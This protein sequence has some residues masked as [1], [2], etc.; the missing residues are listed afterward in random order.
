MGSL[1]TGRAIQLQ[2]LL[3]CHDFVLD[4]GVALLAFHVVLG[5]V[6]FVKEGGVVEGFHTIRKVVAGPTPIHLSGT[7]SNGYVG[8]AL[9]A[10]NQIPNNLLM[11]DGH[12]LVFQVRGGRVASQ[13]P[14]QRLSLG[15]ILE[16]TEGAGGRGYG[17]VF[18]LDDLGMT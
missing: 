6:D 18:S 4:S 14:A 13:A 15:P 9:G 2:R 8:V 17:E 5:N 16:M 1:M 3:Q 7:V 11:V 10:G 12:P